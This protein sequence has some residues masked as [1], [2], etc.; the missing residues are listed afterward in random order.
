M[1]LEQPLCRDATHDT[2]KIFIKSRRRD[3]WYSKNAA[4]KGFWLG[5][6]WHHKDVSS[7]PTLPWRGKQ[8]TIQVGGVETRSKFG[9][10]NLPQSYFQQYPHMGNLE[11][12]FQIQHER[13]ADHHTYV[14]AVWEQ[15]QAAYQTQSRHKQVDT[16]I[17][18]W[19]Y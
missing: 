15:Q 16:Q 13:V 8:Q 7:S 6:A 10:T 2:M 14:R 11:A 17:T 3:E 4:L 18:S 1:A 5:K 9:V 12:H 19:T